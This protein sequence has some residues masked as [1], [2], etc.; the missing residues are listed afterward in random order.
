MNGSITGLRPL[1]EAEKFNHAYPNTTAKQ[2]SGCREAEGHR[3]GGGESWS[4]LWTQSE[5]AQG[6]SSLKEGQGC[7]VLRLL[8]TQAPLEASE[9]L[10]TEW[11]PTKS[12]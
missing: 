8:G 4:E 6:S 11:G 2:V 9:D 7:Q 1:K 3:S 5:L 12:I 10:K